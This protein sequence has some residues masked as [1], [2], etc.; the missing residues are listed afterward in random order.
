ML[1]PLTWPRLRALLQLCPPSLALPCSTAFRYAEYT[2]GYP[3]RDIL[4]PCCCKFASV[5]ASDARQSFAVHHH[6]ELSLHDYVLSSISIPSLTACM[7]LRPST[8]KFALVFHLFL[9]LCFLPD[10]Y[11]STYIALCFPHQS[12]CAFVML[13][14]L[15]RCSKARH[16]SC[17]VQAVSIPVTCANITRG[18]GTLLLLPLPLYPLPL[19]PRFPHVPLIG[20]DLS[21][22]HHKLFTSQA[23]SFLLLLL[24]HTKTRNCSMHKL[25]L[26]ILHAVNQCAAVKSMVYRVMARMHSITECML[27]VSTCPWRFCT[28]ADAVLC[29]LVVM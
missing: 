2:P 9:V 7:S 27:I 29:F 5:T 13:C 11:V 24:L 3:S 14:L 17:A 20:W 22:V 8:F 19:P 26:S 28:T 21:K 4:Y 25:C 1:W 18:P 12:C 6:Q 23:Q 15:E 16:S 10:V